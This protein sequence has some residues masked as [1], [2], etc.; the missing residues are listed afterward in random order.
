MS[1]ESIE[2][3]VDVMLGKIKSAVIE[4][5]TN[6]VL[7]ALAIASGNTI[8][9]VALNKEGLLALMEQFTDQM[10]AHAIAVYRHHHEDQAK[11]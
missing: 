3:K 7:N 11:Q 10:L 4:E 1:Q 5:D 6:A 8:G 2:D 9:A